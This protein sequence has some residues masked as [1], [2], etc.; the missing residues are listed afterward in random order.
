MIGKPTAFRRRP[1]KIEKL[2]Y[3]ENTQIIGDNE[4][5][6]AWVEKHLHHCSKCMNK[7]L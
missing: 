5:S 6:I 3:L 4:S 1:Y 7:E 2:K